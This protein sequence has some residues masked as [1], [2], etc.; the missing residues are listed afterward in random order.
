ML[1]NIVLTF[2]SQISDQARHLILS[3]AFRVWLVY[4]TLKS[5]CK[6]CKVVVM[7]WLRMAPTYFNMPIDHRQVC[8]TLDFGIWVLVL[9]VK[10]WQVVSKTTMTFIFL[11]SG[12]K[13]RFTRLDYRICH[14]FCSKFRR[15]IFTVILITIHFFFWT[16]LWGF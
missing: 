8:S 11:F 14:W 6:L 4:L 13:L 7:H 9:Q 3:G 15:N 1:C 5:E 16:L 2:A 12:F 10:V